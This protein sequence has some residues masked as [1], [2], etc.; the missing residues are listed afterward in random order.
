VFGLMGWMLQGLDDAGRDRALDN[1]RVTV[2]AHETLD[3]VLFD[4][5][6]WLITARR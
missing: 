1:L 4:S 3:G 2:A 5:A 6:T